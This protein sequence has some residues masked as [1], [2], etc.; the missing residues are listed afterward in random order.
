LNQWRT[1]WQALL[2]ASREGVLRTTPPDLHLMVLTKI[3]F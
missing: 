2:E 3:G 1:Q